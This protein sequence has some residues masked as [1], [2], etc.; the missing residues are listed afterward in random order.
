MCTS[1][2]IPIH[3][4]VDILKHYYPGAELVDNYNI[5]T[6]PSYQGIRE[7]VQPVEEDPAAP[8][9]DD[10]TEVAQDDD[11]EPICEDDSK[12]TKP[13]YRDHIEFLLE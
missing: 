3:N 2:G 9:C 4:Y 7:P 11:G 8:V 1:D 13:D 10:D 5:P 6:E 12:Q